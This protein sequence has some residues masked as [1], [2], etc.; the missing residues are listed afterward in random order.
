VLSFLR[1]A[2][3]TLLM[4]FSSGLPLLAIG[5]TL[6]A[7]MT[8]AKVDLTVIG[9][10]SLVGLP[11][12]LKFLWAPAM[13]R[14]V[15][16]FLGRR[17]GWMLISQGCLA[18]SFALLAAGQP[19]AHP[20]VFAGMAVLIA[21]FSATQDIAIDAFRREWLPESELALGSSLVIVGYRVGMLASGALALYLA[22]HV[23]WRTVYLL[24]AATCGVGALT[25]LWADEPAVGAPPRTLSEAVIQP[26]GEFFRRPGAVT[27]LGFVLTYTLG[28][29]MASAM[30]TPCFLAL[31]FEKTDIAAIAKTFGLG[32]L[33]AG[34]VVGG[35]IATRTG[36]HRALWLFGVLQALTILLPAWLAATGKDYPLLMASMTGEMFAA[37]M[38]S[39]ALVA[40]MAGQTDVRY[41]ATQY[42]LLSSLAGIPRVILAAP[43]GWI[44]GHLGWVGY[45]VACS[46]LS[47][48]GLMLLTVVAPWHAPAASPAAKAT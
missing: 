36:T 41:T 22:D 16:P 29:M 13:D 7:W 48:P 44:A 20:V 38:G 30:T 35:A 9:V 2:A 8:D 43:T 37:G 32:A 45:F 39:A 25:T 33:I 4:G 11:Y 28:V 10:F 47:V 26:L 23:P 24:L 15:P 40:F 31:G 1:R 14:F 19:A 42:A 6:Q 5:S 46:A 12:T 18:A 21:F 3:I 34:G 27:I 17:R